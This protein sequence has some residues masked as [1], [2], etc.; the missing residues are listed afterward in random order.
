MK[1]FCV[2]GLNEKDRCFCPEQVKGTEFLNDKLLVAKGK[3][4]EFLTIYK[5]KEV[6]Q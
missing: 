3:K 4:K 1:A 2:P 5:I 6:G